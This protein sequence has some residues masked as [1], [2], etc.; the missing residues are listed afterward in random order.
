MTFHNFDSKW[1]ICI[2]N[3]SLEHSKFDFDIKNDI[4][5]GKFG[6]NQLFQNFGSFSM[7]FFFSKRK[8][9]RNLTKHPLIFFHPHVYKMINYI[10]TNFGI[11]SFDTDCTASDRMSSVLIPPLP[12][13][14]RVNP[15]NY[16]I[17]PTLL[18]MGGGRFATLD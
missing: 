9:F 14:M 6:E 5:Y 8:F 10:Y 4:C 16:D 1:V 12:G 13:P 2:P 11:P 17:C 7:R 18:A 15:N 3:E